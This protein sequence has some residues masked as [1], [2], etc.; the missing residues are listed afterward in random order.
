METELH[1]LND[2]LVKEEIKNEIKDVLKFN[3]NDHNIHKH[4]GHNESSSKRKTHSA[5]CLQKESRE[6]TLAV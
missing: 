2:T 1:L 4:M 5:E 6:H 3:E